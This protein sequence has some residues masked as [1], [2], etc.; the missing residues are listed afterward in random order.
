MNEMLQFIGSFVVAIVWHALPLSLPILYITNHMFLF[1]LVIMIVF[2]QLS[3][4]TWH[5]YFHD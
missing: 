1:I 5:L 4:M 2:I 3:C